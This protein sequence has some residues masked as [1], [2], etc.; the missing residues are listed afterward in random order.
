MKKAAATNAKPAAKAEKVEDKKAPAA[1]SP[2]VPPQQDNKGKGKGKGQ[3]E[4]EPVEVKQEVP[5]ATETKPERELDEMEKHIMARITKINDDIQSRR[6]KIDK[7]QENIDAKKNSNKE[8]QEKQ[9]ELKNSSFN[10][11]STK[12]IVDQLK[13]KQDEIASIQ[14]ARDVK[15]AEKV[16]LIKQLGGNADHKEYLKQLE[17]EIRGLQEKQQSGRIGNMQEEK[18]LIAQIGSLTANKKL[19][20]SYTELNG[21]ILEQDDKIGKIRAEISKLRDDRSEI[22]NKK[23]VFEDQIQDNKAKH[24]TTSTSIDD[25]YTKKKELVEEIKVLE[26]KKDKEYDGLREYRSDRRD[27]ATKKRQD[28]IKKRQDEKKEAEKTR[29]QEDEAKGFYSEE[30]TACL[31]LVTYL[32]PL[33]FK[34]PEPEEEEEREKKEGE[35]ENAAAGEGEE[36]EK[37][38]DEDVSSE[39][40]PNKRASKKKPVGETDPE[41]ELKHTTQIYYQFELISLSAPSKVG[42]VENVITKI[43]EKKAYLEKQQVDRKDS[44]K[45]AFTQSQSDE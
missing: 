6:T 13:K 26:D 31:Q 41:R 28:E 27:K 29:F 5:P 8:I 3:Q 18:K 10:E 36:K 12:D 11:G 25:E 14:K 24:E 32:E 16:K 20:K 23:K 30:I 35:S 43:N 19:Y 22:M 33:K 1:N 37:R 34:A 15:Y 21:A 39:T 9:K 44:R 38:E 17:A 2:K 42:D 45:K 40:R 7:I 4:P